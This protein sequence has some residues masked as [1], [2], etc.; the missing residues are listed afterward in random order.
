M[1]AHFLQGK[2][3]IEVAPNVADA[4]RSE[5]LVFWVIKITLFIQI[6][7]GEGTDEIKFC[8]KLFY[9]SEAEIGGVDK[10]VPLTA[11]NRQPF[12]DG[13][14]ES[15]SLHCRAIHGQDCMGQ[16]DARIPAGDRTVFGI[17]DE[18]AGA[19]LAFCPDDKVIGIRAAHVVE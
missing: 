14:R 6:W 13:T 16:V 3:D 9:G 18:Q 5:T 8:I 7:V 17:K 12:V 11:T 1:L 15:T 2:G 19:R 4:E 10:V